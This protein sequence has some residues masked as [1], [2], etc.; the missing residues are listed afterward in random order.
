MWF[1]SGY[2]QDFLVSSWMV[3]SSVLAAYPGLAV[4]PS[5]GARS[6]HPWLQR[7]RVGSQYTRG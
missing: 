2:L 4:N 7:S 3:A 6:R 5:M 1:A